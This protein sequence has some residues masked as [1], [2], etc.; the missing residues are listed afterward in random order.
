MSLNGIMSDESGFSHTLEAIIGA[1]L[2]IGTVI[3]VTGSIPHMEQKTGEYSKVQLVDIGRDILDLVVV[4]PRYETCPN[5][6]DGEVYRNYTLVAN[7]RFVSPG[8]NVTFTVYD[9]GE[10]NIIYKNLTLTSST[11]GLKNDVIIGPINGTTSEKFMSVGEFSV[12]AVDGDIY[13]P[14][15]WSNYVTI[16]VGHYFLDTDI[17]GVSS[18]G[19]RLVYGTVYNSTGFGIPGLNIEILGSDG[20]TIVKS[21]PNNPITK[22]NYGRVIEGFENI[23]GWISDRS[24]A[25]NSTMK[26]EGTSSLSLSGNS[27]SFWVEK[28]NKTPYNL[29]YYDIVSFDLFTMTKNETID[30]ELMNSTMPG[31]FVWKNIGTNNIGWN[32]INLKLYNFSVNA[33]SLCCHPNYPTIEGSMNASNVD[34]IMITVSNVTGNCLIDNLVAGNGNFLFNWTGKNI[35]QPGSYYIRANDSINT[36]NNHRIIFSNKGLLLNDD[37]FIYEGQTT[38]IRLIPQPSGD[39]QDLYHLERFKINLNYYKP[40]CFDMSKITM[41]VD[42]S[43]PTGRTVNFTGNIAGD[44]YIFYGET[45]GGCSSGGGP[46]N[47]DPAA[48]A[49]TNSIVIHVLPLSNIGSTGD[50]ICVDKN[51][52]NKYIVEYMPQYVNYNLYLI[53]S[54]GDR[55]T[56]CTKFEDGE[57]INGYPTKD[58]VTVNKL[59]HI[60]YKDFNDILEFR[61]VMWYK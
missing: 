11:L 39:P 29:N 43:D 21:P 50:D 41:V 33:G 47:N 19:S 12:R 20:T 51:I 49:K 58:A 59:V 22:T 35:E 44:Y 26:T 27:S 4:T 48:G 1:V 14:I 45:A 61:I 7:K 2:I 25:L 5:C 36:S 60:K 8:E 53:D 57:L 17:D 9:N 37:D 24:I 42:S 54:R 55:F 28:T 30:V 15:T 34:M 10:N 31:K 16:N 56:E 38:K 3:F 18:N 52:L 46:Q 6:L 23:S 13:N 32:K 40:A